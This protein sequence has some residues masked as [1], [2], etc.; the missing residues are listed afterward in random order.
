M[1][2]I[3][4]RNIIYVDC[5]ESRWED[6]VFRGLVGCWKTVV[7]GLWWHWWV[8]GVLGKS[9][10][11]CWCLGVPRRARLSANPPNRRLEKAKRSSVVHDG[12]R[13]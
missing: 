13:K 5:I 8:T 2:M 7:I 10:C 4:L 6:R 11:G 3:I 12:P 1:I 9:Q